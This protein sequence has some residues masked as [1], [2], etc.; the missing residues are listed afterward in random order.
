MVVINKLLTPN[1]DNEQNYTNKVCQRDFTFAYK[2]VNHTN[3]SPIAGIPKM[4]IHAKAIKVQKKNKKQKSKT[5]NSTPKNA[6]KK[7]KKH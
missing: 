4:S 7:K 3:H 2:Y 5:R 1:E 6:N